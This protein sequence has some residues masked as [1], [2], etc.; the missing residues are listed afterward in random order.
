MNDYESLN[1]IFFKL[2]SNIYSI[3]ITERKLNYKNLNEN[4]KKE[5]I[6]NCKILLK[7]L[8]KRINNKIMI[9]G[10]IDKHYPELIKIRDIL[11]DIN[12][13]KNECRS[14]I[15]IIFKN[16]LGFDKHIPLGI[17]IIFENFIKGITYFKD[18]IEKTLPIYHRAASC[19]NKKQNFRKLYLENNGTEEYKKK[20]IYKC[21][22]ER[23]IY[24]D[25]YRNL[26]LF[27]PK[28]T[29][30]NDHKQ[31]EGHKY[32]L[33]ERAKN[34]YNYFTGNEIEINIMYEGKFPTFMIIHYKKNGEI[35]KREE[36]I[37]T[38]YVD[39]YG[40][41]QY[42]DN[43]FKTTIENGNKNTIIQEF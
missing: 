7:E 2:Y 17:T 32:Q 16:I 20:H 1:N 40:N 18:E 28:S 39:D 43:V 42:S 29:D 8:R 25:M 19:G 14:L 22:L 9:Q 41:T 12:S 4:K 10:L 36:Y 11:I 5:I 33:N 6:D 23:L 37:K 34:F 30:E 13:K 21:Y 3:I 15:D 24:D 26:T 38:T 31:N 27:F 35:I